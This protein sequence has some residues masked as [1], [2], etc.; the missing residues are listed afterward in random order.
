[1][2][3]IQNRRLWNRADARLAVLGFSKK[4]ETAWFI[5][6]D[7]AVHRLII[8]RKIGEIPYT[9]QYGIKPE[10]STLPISRLRWEYP[11][12]LIPKKLRRPIRRKIKSLGWNRKRDVDVVAR[13]SYKKR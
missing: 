3:Y 8:H 11:N 4:E 9:I 2:I 6:Y 7:S 10:D 12:D 5:I 13:L 1:M